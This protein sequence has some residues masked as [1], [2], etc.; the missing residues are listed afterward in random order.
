MNMRYYP[1][2]HLD[3]NQSKGLELFIVGQSKGYKNNN[4]FIISSKCN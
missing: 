4:I 3:T 2:L 1:T